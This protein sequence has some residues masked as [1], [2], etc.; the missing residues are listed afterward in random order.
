MCGLRAPVGKD[1]Q[2]KTA[3]APD[4]EG[5]LAALYKIE[6]GLPGRPANDPKHTIRT[7]VHGDRDNMCWCC[8]VVVVCISI[9]VCSHLQ[10][11]CQSLECP[12]T[13]SHP[14]QP[15]FLRC[16]LLEPAQRVSMALSVSS[17][18]QLSCSVG[19]S[20]ASPRVRRDEHEDAAWVDEVGTSVDEPKRLREPAE[21]VR[22]QH[23]VE[24]AQ[25]TPQRTCIALSRRPTPA[26]NPQRDH[27]LWQ[28]R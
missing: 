10:L 23:S 4:H 26:S 2:V 28:A 19:T 15:L 9:C 25:I 8:V 24:G 3:C 27:N 14:T 12:P 11:G 1:R 21:Q 7:T 17:L 5:H 13:T 6:I 20:G 18:I 16:V 22:G